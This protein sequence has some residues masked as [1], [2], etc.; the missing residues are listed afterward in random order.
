LLGKLLDLLLLRGQGV[1]QGLN[2]GSGYR[3]LSRRRHGLVCLLW[4]GGSRAGSLGPSASGECRQRQEREERLLGRFHKLQS[5][6]LLIL[7]VTFSGETK[8][9]LT[10][11]AWSHALDFLNL[12][13]R[14]AI[15]P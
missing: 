9:T 11:E 7:V 4:L 1:F 14:P 15:M 8:T 6:S 3:R 13:P 10:R 2:V 5:L 12:I